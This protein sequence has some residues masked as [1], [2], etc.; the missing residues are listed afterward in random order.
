LNQKITLLVIA[1]RVSTLKNCDLIVD[2]RQN[3]LK[4]GKF[5]QIVKINK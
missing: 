1:H 5:S 4:V 3:G 2:L